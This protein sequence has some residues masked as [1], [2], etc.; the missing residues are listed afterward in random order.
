MRVDLQQQQEKAQEEDQI[1]PTVRATY[2][3]TLIDRNVKRYILS[4]M[5]QF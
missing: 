4:H 5:L 3:C 2:G 1:M